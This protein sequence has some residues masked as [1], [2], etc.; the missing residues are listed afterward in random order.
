MAERLLDRYTTQTGRHWRDDPLEACRWFADHR[1]QWRKG[2]WRAYKAALITY[3][4]FHGPN[5]VL[6]Y[7]Q[8][9]TDTG[10]ASGRRHTAKVLSDEDLSALLQSISPSSSRFD[11][12]LGLWLVAGRA[13]GL[14]PIEWKTAAVQD[15]TLVVE[16]AKQ[17][18]QARNRYLD[19]NELVDAERAVV[20]RFLTMIEAEADFAAAYNGCRIRLWHLTRKLW[21]DRDQHPTLY[22]GRHQFTTDRRHHGR[23]PA[24]IALM[25]GHANEKVQ[26]LYGENR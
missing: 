24:E 7:L 3:M 5:E 22:S 25:L 20:V 26:R 19:L 6:E 12:L 10:C 13:T 9:Q 18:G 1:P 11:L 23:T 2:T 16:T 4:R 8:A 15:D 14:R 21:P 17:R